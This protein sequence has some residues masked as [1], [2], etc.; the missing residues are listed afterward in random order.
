MPV[1]FGQKPTITSLSPAR[2]AS[3]TSVVVTGTNFATTDNIITIDGLRMAVSAATSTALT[4]TAPSKAIYGQVM[5]TNTVTGRTGSSATFFSNIHSKV[6]STLVSDFEAVSSLKGLGIAALKVADFDLDGKTDLIIRDSENSGLSILRNNSTSA[7]NISFELPISLA[8]KTSYFNLSSAVQTFDMDGDGKPDIVIINEDGSMSIYLN[9]HSSGALSAASFSRVDIVGAAARDHLVICDIDGDGR[10]DLISK[11]SNGLNVMINQSSPGQLDAGSFSTPISIAGTTNISQIAAADLNGDGKP[12][13]LTVDGYTSTVQLYQNQTT[14]QH[15]DSSSLLKIELKINAGG[16]IGIGIADFNGDGLLDL[17]ISDTNGFISLLENIYQSGPLTSTSFSW[18]QRAYA[19]KNPKILWPVDTDGDGKVDLFCMNQSEG[20]LAIFRNIATTGKAPWLSRRKTI[21][22]GFASRHLAIADFN[23][24]GLMDIASISNDNTLQFRRNIPS[25][26]PII[27]SISPTA[28]PTGTVV[29]ITGKHLFTDPTKLQVFFG[30]RK[31][32]IV[33]T[34]PDIIQVSVPSG[35]SY[36]DLTVIDNSAN[37]QAKSA[38]FFRTTFPQKQNMH[39]R[40]FRL[41]QSRLAASRNMIS[42]DKESIIDIDGDGFL[43]FI[44]YDRTEKAFFVHQNAASGKIDCNTFSK[45]IQLPL[46]PLDY[47]SHIADIDNDGLVDILVQNQYGNELGYYKNISK[48]GTPAF[49]SYVKLISSPYYLWV[50]SVID[51]DGDGRLDIISNRIFRNTSKSNAPYPTFEEINLNFPSYT[52]SKTIITDLNG[53][54]KKDFIQSDNFK[55]ISM[56]SLNLSSPGMISD[57]TFTPWTEYKHA[58]NFTRDIDGDGK[59]DVIG[60]NKFY[61]NNSSTGGTVS[62]QAPHV[63]SKIKII[64]YADLNGDGKEEAF[65]LKD[66][67][68]LGD[69]F[70]DTLSVYQNRAALGTTPIFTDSIKLSYYEVLWES[71]NGGVIHLPNLV[72]IMDLNNDGRPEIISMGGDNELFIFENTTNAIASTPAPK[73]TSF[74]PTLASLGDQVKI[75]GTGFNPVAALNQ[76]FI[77]NQRAEVVSSSSNLLTIKV[78]SGAVHGN[79]IVRDSISRLSHTS[80]GALSIKLKSGSGVDIL[81]ESFLLK[82]KLAE[83][84]SF[85]SLLVVDLDNDQIPEIATGESKNSYPYESFICVYRATTRDANNLPSGYQLA[86]RIKT[87]TNPHNLQAT[88]LDGDGR[89]D[90]IFNSNRGIEILEN[91]STSNCGPTFQLDLLYRSD[92]SAPKFTLGDLDND[93]KT[94]I[95]L[96]DGTVYFNRSQNGNIS[97]NPFERQKLVLPYTDYMEVRDF[98][99]NGLNDVA[100]TNEKGQLQI[101]L[102]TGTGSYGEVK[103]AAPFTTGPVLNRLFAADLNGDGRPDLIGSELSQLLVLQN[104]SVPGTLKFDVERTDISTPFNASAWNPKIYISDIDGDGRPELLTLPNIGPKLG[105]HKNITA[106]GGQGQILFDKTHYLDYN[107]IATDMANRLV[108]TDI[109]ND[110]RADIVLPSTNDV[111]VLLNKLLSTGIELTSSPGQTNYTS[112]SVPVVVD[113]K[114]AL[115][116]ELKGIS[117]AQVSISENFVADEDLLS[118]ITDDKRMGNIQASY[119]KKTGVLTLSSPQASA[120]ASQWQNALSAITYANEQNYSGRRTVSFRIHA[121]TV[122]SDLTT[123]SVVL[124]M[125]KAPTLLDFSPRIATTGTRIELKGTDFDYVTAVNLGGMAAGSFTIN[126][127]TS[128]TLIVGTGTSGT[129]TVENSSGTTSLP[130]FQFIPKPQIIH[131]AP[132]QLAPNIPS[133]LL[134]ANTGTRYNYQWER[135]GA[136]IPNASSTNYLVTNAGSYVVSILSNNL[137]VSSDPLSIPYVLP[138]NNLKLGATSVTCKSGNNGSI[139]IEAATTANYI[140][141]LKVEGQQ[142]QQ[143]P[144]NQ[145]LTIPN[146]KAGTYSLC[147]TLANQE[148]YEHCT[149]LIVPEPKDLAIYTVVMSTGELELN[150]NGGDS[151]RILWN[152]KLLTTD[153]SRILLPLQTGQNRLQVSTNKACQGTIEKT[154]NLSD[155]TLVYPNPFERELK[156]SLPSG[157]TGSAIFS[158]SNMAGKQVYQFKQVIET[159]ELNLSLGHLPKGTY[160]L[161]ISVGQQQTIHKIQKK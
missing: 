140:A 104:K 112:K 71:P 66:G 161:T 157:Q 89:M 50:N 20:T 144:F 146:L 8:T 121:G 130:G 118:L 84:G 11:S 67:G 132:P 115:F 141:N 56:V 23:Q 58:I 135:N 46:P 59:I 148:G 12:E 91:Q 26:I 90:L 94:D 48:P 82:E 126:S 143:L 153:Q 103:L 54:G 129:V 51:I 36:S 42:F 120:S 49:A 92:T 29:T 160:L 28:G 21:A 64:E 73:I 85:Y 30:S 9:K 41:L 138:P 125:T 122:S 154:F 105:I 128:I 124:S 74:S 2:A 24:D 117:L 159:G 147:I 81:H 111:R 139:S 76:V 3:G 156:I 34:S 107:S 68:D 16:A 83:K 13:L 63:V 158:V 60:G 134:S 151:Y 75:N 38:T 5:V 18:Q 114:I 27:S 45:R 155:Q 142:Q 106:A 110:G 72:A 113:P 88:D 62:F 6:D 14:G 102:N 137:K 79:L 100:L 116:T 55:N 31:A 61:R 47:G 15:F 53:D 39:A 43:D 149:E 136:I 37:R 109:N 108:V 133:L 52:S 98:D 70:Q 7:S 57:S 96:F 17:A 44:I 33:Q 119:D 123:K 150:L 131:S 152:G 10:P 77:G 78:P 93:G 22:V 4:F 145:S 1:A 80:S 97:F 99:G 32:K 127:S 69:A 35:V 86:F 40:D 101:Y 95:V 19:G 25:I 65:Y 87:G